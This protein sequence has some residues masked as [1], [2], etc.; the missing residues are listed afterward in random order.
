M[1]HKILPCVE[2]DDKFIAEKL[3]EVADSKIDFE[4][5]IEDEL[6]VFKDI[7]T[8]DARDWNVGFF[9]KSGYTVYCTLEDYPSGHSKYK[10]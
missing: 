8:I 6:V 3:N 2:G 4:D 1:E 7:V 10:M 5:T 9:K